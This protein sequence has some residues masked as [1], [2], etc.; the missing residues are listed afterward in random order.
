MNK[1]Y[2]LHSGTINPAKRTGSGM[3]YYTPGEC[4]LVILRAHHND[5]PRAISSAGEFFGMNDRPEFHM[6]ERVVQVK[7]SSSGRDKEIGATV[8][9]YID[10]AGNEF[11]EVPN[12][13]VQ[14]FVYK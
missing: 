11:G 3:A 1:H 13:T 9:G 5:A 10:T 6:G 12:K 14:F 8:I 4:S 7:Q 2:S